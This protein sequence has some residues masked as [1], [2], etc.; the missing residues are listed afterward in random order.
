MFVPVVLK[1][2]GTTDSLQSLTN[3]GE[4]PKKYLN[5]RTPRAELTVTSTYSLKIRDW[6]QYLNLIKIKEK[7][8]LFNVKIY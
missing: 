8:H 1:L 2:S 7:L 4:S 3:L 5:S 6:K